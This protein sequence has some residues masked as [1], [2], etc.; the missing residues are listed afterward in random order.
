MPT[1]HVA[2]VLFGHIAVCEIENGVASFTEILH[3]FVPTQ[4][5]GL[6]LNTHKNGR[7]A[8]VCVTVVKLGDVAFMQAVD[9]GLESPRLLGNGHR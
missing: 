4:A 5:T 7:L 2:N 6:H 3:Q 1:D 9:K 8:C